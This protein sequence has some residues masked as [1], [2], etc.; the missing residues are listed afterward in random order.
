[1]EQMS[2]AR[3]G[4]P[5]G[6]GKVGLK[7]YPGRPG[8]G[9]ILRPR[10]DQQR[11]L[12]LR[13]RWSEAPQI[14][15]PHQGE[16]PLPM[17]PLGQEVRV[18]LKLRRR[19][20]GSGIGNETSGQALR[21]RP[22]DEARKP[23]GIACEQLRRRGEEPALQARQGQQGRGQEPQGERSADPHRPLEAMLKKNGRAGGMAEGQGPG[24]GQG[25]KRIPQACRQSLPRWAKAWRQGT[26]PMARKIGG[27]ERP[28]ALELLGQWPKG[29]GRSPRTVKREDRARA[30]G[31][32]GEDP[33][34]AMPRDPNPF[35]HGAA[36]LRGREAVTSWAMA[37]APWRGKGA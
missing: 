31:K 6:A 3:K 28:M 7:G 24:D 29:M 10:Q 1:M 17:G 19:K 27:P 34:L 25:G 26:G 15:V 8:I 33:G 2:E 37:A 32:P 14:P 9:A 36:A 21:G 11:I 18:A 20:G 23:G 22:G 35:D 16:G 5:D 12:N 13:K 30:F 4:S